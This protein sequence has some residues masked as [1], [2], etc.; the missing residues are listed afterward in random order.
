VLSKQAS[1]QSPFRVPA[2]VFLEL[3]EERTCG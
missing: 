2:P 3:F 1:T